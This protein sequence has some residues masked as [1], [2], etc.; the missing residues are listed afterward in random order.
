MNNKLFILGLSMTS[1]GLCYSQENKGDVESERPNVLLCVVDDVNFGHWGCYGNNWVSTPSCD[2]VAKNGVLFNRV[3]TPNAK[4]GPSRSCLLTGLTSWQLEDAANHFAYFPSH[5]KTFTEVLREN[6]YAVAQTGKG[7]FP[8]E[9][10]ILAD[11]SARVLIGKQYNRIKC[12]PETEKM[13]KID[14]AANFN[15]FLAKRQKNKPFLF[16]YGSWEAHRPY[17]LGS[18]IAKAGK[19][20][21][22]VDSVPTIYPDCPTVREDMC[23]Y[24]LEVEYFDKH[25]GRMVESLK[26]KGLLENTLIIVTS[27]NGMSFPRIKGQCY[28]DSHHMPMVMMWS[29]KIPSGGVNNDFISFTDI[30]P[31]ILDAVCIDGV[32]SGMKPMEGRSLLAQLCSENS[33]TRDFVLIGKERHDVGRPDDAGYPIRGIVTKEWMY[34][35]N[36]EPGRGPAGTAETGYLNYDGNP[37]KHLLLEKQHDS[38]WIPY[39]E[40]SF[41]MR[42]KEELYDLKSDTDCVHNLA[43]DKSRAKICRELRN[44]MFAA[45]KSDGDPRMFGNGALFDAYPHSFE[46]NRD[47]YNR[48]IRT[49]TL[50]LPNWI[51]VQDVDWD[52]LKEIREEYKNKNR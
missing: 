9:P 18:G 40:L 8:G 52:K 1:C 2:F 17:E 4:S 29:A 16:W 32:K 31:T 42:P 47:Y 35:Y 19:R 24:A 49:D 6:G 25:L 5:I 20:L 27:D 39:F 12:T 22:M 15:D 30:A 33:G 38:Q 34:I 46:Q 13:S 10:G 44:K 50:Q 43:A 14:Y 48:L 51:D 21:D 7:W 11:G 37:T 41:G 3:F 28:Y 26:E 45:L 23:D 36:F